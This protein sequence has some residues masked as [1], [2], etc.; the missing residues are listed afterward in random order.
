MVFV[1][2]SVGGKSKIN[3]FSQRYD[4]AM[5]AVEQLD[6]VAVE[7]LLVDEEDVPAEAGRKKRRKQ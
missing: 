1:H 5:G 7:K 3:L 4:E 2:F 6:P